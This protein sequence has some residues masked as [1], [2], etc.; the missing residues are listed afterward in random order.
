[1][2][3]RHSDFALFQTFCGLFKGCRYKHRDSSLGDLVASQ[4]Y[5]DLVFQEA[6]EAADRLRHRAQSYFDEF[7]I[8]P[9]RATNVAPFPFEWVDYE[10]T[11]MECSALLLR[12]SRLYDLRF[13]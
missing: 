9:F 1:M 5:E 4:L 3:S 7:Q 10:Q 12:V 11:S 13:P 6:D 2:P 8:L